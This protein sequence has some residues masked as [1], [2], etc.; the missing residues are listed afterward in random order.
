MEKQIGSYTITSAGEV[1]GQNGQKL[2]ANPDGHPDRKYPRV[3]LV[4]PEGR[5]RVFVHR[6]VAELFI[7]NIESK[8]CVNHKDNNPNNNNVSNLEWV[9]HSENTH[10]SWNKTEREP[11]K[12]L[13]DSSRKRMSEMRNK[14]DF[15]ILNTETGIFYKTIEE[16]AATVSKNKSAFNWRMSNSKKYKF[17]KV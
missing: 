10:H 1:F 6:L 15:F 4:L 9:T 16:A 12:A 5:R 7:P 11:S 14:T 13:R 2:K 17:K 8:P 3:L